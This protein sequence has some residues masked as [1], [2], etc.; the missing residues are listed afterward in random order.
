MTKDDIKNGK[1]NRTALPYGLAA[2][3]GWIKLAN[4]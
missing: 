3:F 4:R 2:Y 1:K